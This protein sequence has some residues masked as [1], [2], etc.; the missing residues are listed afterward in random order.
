MLPRLLGTKLDSPA[1]PTDVTFTKFLRSSAV[2][3][4]LHAH[5][6]DALWTVDSPNQSIEQLGDVLSCF[7]GWGWGAPREVWKIE[8]RVVL[9]ECFNPRPHLSETI[10]ITMWGLLPWAAPSCH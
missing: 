10:P 1:H 3:N 2:G 4:D 9:G 7:L 5:L 6:A 8:E